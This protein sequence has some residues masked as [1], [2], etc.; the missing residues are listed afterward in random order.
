MKIKIL[1]QGQSTEIIVKNPDWT[2]ARALWLSG[3]VE[4]RALCSGL[5][6]C[7]A[8]RVKFLSSPPVPQAWDLEILGEDAVKNGFRLACRQPV[9]AGLELELP[10]F[11][12]AE[13]EETVEKTGIARGV[14]KAGIA[15]KIEKIVEK[16]GISRVGIGGAGIAETGGLSEVS[17]FEASKPC[18]TV[19]TTAL[20]LAVDWGTTSV[21]WQVWQGEQLLEQG[22]KFNPQMGAGA[23]IIS[24]LRFCLEADGLAL[25]QDLS[26]KFLAE[27]LQQYPGITQICLA[28]NTALTSI[29]LGLPIQGLAFSPYSVGYAGGQV[30]VSDLMEI[31]KYFHNSELMQSQIVL[32]LPMQSPTPGSLP[33]QSQR[34]PCLSM[35]LYIPPPFAPFVGGDV[36]AGLA[37]ILYELQ[38]KF[39]FMLWDLGT[40]GECILAVDSETFYCTS[41]PLG[42]ALEGIGLRYGG[43]AQTGSVVDFSLQVK[44]LQPITIDNQPAQNICAAGYLA[45][46]EILLRL[47]VLQ[48]G[49]QWDLKQ[50]WTKK[51]GLIQTSAGWFLPLAGHLGLEAR[52]VEEILKVKAALSV[53]S[54]SLLQLARLQTSDLQQIFLGGALGQ[55]VKIT[56]LERLFFPGQASKLKVLG[57]TS[58]AGARLLLQRPKLRP[59]LQSLKCTALNLSEQ[60]GF[61]EEYLEQMHF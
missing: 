17:A 41:V 36:S 13:V 60:P 48:S 9:Q 45:L 11:K 6:S 31:E 61:M 43:V 23:D 7:G 24:R 25:L 47:G 8:C 50:V 3:Q 12:K 22:K 49:G 59:I 26:W 4:P 38:P 56:A 28:A 30:A 58:L 14:E 53:A 21:V 54:Q 32:P 19:E 15:R 46:I 39:P 16:I 52:D 29:L 42:P 34:A 51:L 40:N 55:H 37:H 33:M 57:N 44:G 2:L 18:A 35:Q 27:I 1:E 5:G 10:L 20:S